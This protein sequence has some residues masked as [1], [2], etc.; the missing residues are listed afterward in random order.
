MSSKKRR[1]SDRFELDQEILKISRICLGVFFF[2]IAFGLFAPTEE[3]GL[4]DPSWLRIVHSIFMV[5]IFTGT[6]ISEWVKKHLPNLLNL[7]FYTMSIHSFLVLYWNG[8]NISYLIGMVLVISCIGISFVQRRLLVYYLIFVVIASIPVGLFTKNPSIP[9][10]LYFL[11]IFT[12]AFVSYLT[13]NVRL[14]AIEK[15]RE[16]EATL[17]EFYSRMNY[18]LEIAHETQKSLVSLNLP[19]TKDFR[20][21]GYYKSFDKVGGDVLSVEERPDGKFNILFADV[22]GHGIS[23]AMVS[24]MAILAFKIVSRSIMSPKESLFV[25]NELLKPLVVNHH[26]S[27]CFA[28]M[29]TKSKQFHYS[30]AGHQ[31]IVLIQNQEIKFLEGRGRPLL[32]PIPPQLNDYKIPIFSGDRLLFYSDGIYEIFNPEGHF[33]G[34]DGFYKSIQKNSNLKGEDFLKAIVEDSLA[35]SNG[36]IDDD[37]T[38]LS[39]EMR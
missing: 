35:F 34:L 5:S 11:T 6:Y 30:Y 23:S 7:S 32:T 26:I 33:Y 18:D 36:K 24:G 15:L 2:F 16:R 4:Y 9:I 29:D 39:I 1:K 22:S 10:H 8:L 20:M 14:N 21:V 37:I 3:L 12:P 19:E 17:K 25:M 28:T 31:E 13:L 38:L 27:A